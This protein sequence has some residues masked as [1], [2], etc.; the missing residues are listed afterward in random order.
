MIFGFKLLIISSMYPGY[1]RE[2]YENNPGI[3]SAAY[4]D[5]YDSLLSDST[6]FAASYTRSFCNNGIPAVCIIAND[7]RLQRKWLLENNVRAGNTEE[8]I[9]KRISEFQPDVLWIED[10]RF[11]S[12]TFIDDLRKKAAYIKLYV[13]YHCAPINLSNLDKLKSLDLVITCTPGLKLEFESAGI[14]SYLVYHGFDSDLLPAID[15]FEN[16]PVN[17]VLFSGSLFQ[18]YGYHNSRIRLIENLV[19]KN[20]DLQL[21]AEIES[22]SMLAQR[23][24]LFST[25]RILVSIGIKHPEKLFSILQHGKQKVLLYSK[26]LRSKTKKPEY[27]LKMYSLLKCSRIILNSHGDVAG[28]YAGNM[29]LFE[30]TGTGSCL[31][32]DYKSN[33]EELFEVGKEIV[34]YNDPDDCAEKIKWLLEN[35][36]E[37]MKIALAGQKRTLLSHTVDSRTKSILEILKSEHHFGN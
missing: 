29:R 10:F 24:I 13:G 22:R 32:T 19:S 12:L 8:Y 18:G 6:E 20:I 4:D 7:K 16:F 14:K 26:M 37:R 25:Y 9:L 33:L 36:S 15:S 35:D 34:V 27:G 17:N 21:Y 28:D 3:H 5:H 11:T 1:L 30:A 23:Q 31:L 2:F